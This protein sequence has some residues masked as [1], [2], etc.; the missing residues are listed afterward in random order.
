MLRGR[1]VRKVTGAELERHRPAGPGLEAHLGERLEL[2]DRTGDLGLRVADVQLDDLLAG[3]VAGVG[4]GTR[5]GYGE[6]AVVGTAEDGRAQVGVLERG[7]GQAV[8]E[9]IAGV[10]PHGVIAAIADEDAFAVPDVPLLA[11][12]VQVRRVVLQAPRN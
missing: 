11:G 9:W 3:P 7:V 1:P 12:E 2:A 10:V 6:A 4:D 5:D 8:A